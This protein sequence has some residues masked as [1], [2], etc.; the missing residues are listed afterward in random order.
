MQLICTFVFP[1]AK[2][3][4]SHDAALSPDRD[5]YEGKTVFPHCIT[6][7]LSFNFRKLIVATGVS[8]PVIPTIVGSEY[9]DGYEDMSLDRDDYE[10]QTVLIL[11]TL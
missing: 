5:D 4:F 8:Q 10:G 9:M 1:N 3:R 7:F 11:G 6:K 2:C